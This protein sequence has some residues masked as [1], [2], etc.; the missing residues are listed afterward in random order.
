MTNS[1]FKFLNAYD[2]ADKDQFF[3][4]DA[5]VEELYRLVFQTSLVLVY[6]TSGT[7]KT[8]LIQCGLANRFQPTDW[9]ELFVRRG[10]DINV[11]LDQAIRTRADTPI[12]ADVSVVDA[13][14]S[15][16]LD[17][18]RPV[19]LI[20]DQFEELFI[21]GSADEQRRFFETVA[22]VLTSTIS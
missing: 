7:G 2:R 1:P 20:F 15:L 21:M 18:L 22:A 4:R 10:D 12:V 6:G 8:S 13:V 16:Y 3:G 9:F 19:Y 5:E 14:Q 17:Y 11:S